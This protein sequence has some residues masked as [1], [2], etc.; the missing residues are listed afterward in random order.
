MTRIRS[1]GSDNRQAKWKSCDYVLKYSDAVWTCVYVYM[2]ICSTRK[3]CEYVFKF[4]IHVSQSPK[5]HKKHLSIW[6][7]KK[8]TCTNVAKTSSSINFMNSAAQSSTRPKADFCL[9]AS[10]IMESRYKNLCQVFRTLASL[11]SIS[12]SSNPQRKQK[13]TKLSTSLPS[14]N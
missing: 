3:L 12:V 14:L 13:D 9:S 2:V 6:Q 1:A 8:Y 10:S 11:Y 4:R 7:R 5:L